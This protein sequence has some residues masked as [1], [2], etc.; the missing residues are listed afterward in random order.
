MA[1]MILQIHAYQ[2]RR[3]AV[4]LENPEPR[5]PGRFLRIAFVISVADEA[6]LPA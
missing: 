5:F 1:R 6:R 4:T 3:N 2:S